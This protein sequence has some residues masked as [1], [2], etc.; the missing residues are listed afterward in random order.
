M[1]SASALLSGSSVDAV[2][3]HILEDVDSFAFKAYRERM[4]RTAA[5][6]MAYATA[7]PALMFDPSLHDVSLRA[8]GEHEADY[9]DRPKFART[10]T[11]RVL[12]S[13]IQ[14]CTALP[15]TLK[16]SEPMDLAPLT[17]RLSW[18]T[19]Q[20]VTETTGTAAVR[21]VYD[22][23]TGSVFY[24][25]FGAHQLVPYVAGAQD[26][27]TGLVVEWGDGIRELWTESSFL[28]QRKGDT[29][30]QG[31]NPL[32]EIPFSIFRTR[33]HPTLWWGVSD[34]AV[35]TLNNIAVN[36]VWSDLMQLASE[37]SFAIY[38]VYEDEVGDPVEDTGEVSDEPSTR[39]SYNWTSGKTVFVPHNGKVETISP[40]AD[41][42]AIANVV[43]TMGK[44]SL[45]DAYIIDIAQSQAGQSGFSLR[46]RMQPYLNKSSAIRACFKPGVQ[47]LVEL[48]AVIEYAG[49]TG[50]SV[51]R[52][53]SFSVSAEWDTTSLTPVPVDETVR[54]YEWEHKLGASS[55]VDYL[56]ETRGL[57]REEAERRVDQV[58]T[59]KE[60]GRNGASADT[61]ALSLAAQRLGSVGDVDG[62]NAVRRQLFGALDETVPDVETLTRPAPDVTR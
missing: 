54:R 47:H 28:I 2:L 1:A 23:A 60:A 41:I 61:N 62:Y 42:A 40:N 59:D 58:R 26:L 19:I 49:R 57:S 51:S 50:L 39:A 16:S 24:Q 29:V 21:P 17:K 12:D 25:I 35:V 4:R 34:L 43:E 27:L 55:S 11:S 13:R 20:T 56:M 22:A 44:R 3:G 37:Q 46:V 6:V 45:D 30:G 9:R 38:V 53:R 36:K 52:N 32:G 14:G 8:A 48:A 5:L 15:L 7:D 18:E 33:R 10:L 31:V